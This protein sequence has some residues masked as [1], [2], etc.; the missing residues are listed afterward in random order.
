MKTENESEQRVAIP[1]AN[2][3]GR[4]KPGERERILA[5]WAEHGKDVHQVVRETGWS[6]WTL[7]RW[8][9]HAR[10]GETN[11]GGKL[12]SANQAGALVAV[13]APLGGAAA[14]EV[15]TRLGVIRVFA[16]APAGWV[17]EVLREVQ[18]C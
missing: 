11:L 9:G 1:S 16:T 15:T 3:L 6:E 4:P 2:G 12:R 18:R 5:D 13:P 10:R 17:A 8:R 7:Y 14:A